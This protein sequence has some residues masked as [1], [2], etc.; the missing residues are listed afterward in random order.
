MNDTT[1]LEF[2]SPAW[3]AAAREYLLAQSADAD[4]GG[5][6]V[7]FNE[8]FTDPPAHLDPDGT[9]RIG[10]YLRVA[11]GAVEVG[12]GVLPGADLR[13]TVDYETVLPAARRLST[14]A[15][16]EAEQTVLANAIHRD[17]DPAVMTGVPWM[18]GL[19][20]AMAVLTR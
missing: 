5:V 6:D 19:H 8:V 11:D 18:V 12:A 13:L 7:A 15:L 20:D 1:K 3:I 2:C 14:D 10:W 4:L 17:G 16:D 9:G